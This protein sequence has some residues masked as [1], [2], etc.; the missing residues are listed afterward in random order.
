MATPHASA[1]AAVV[2]SLHTGCSAEQIR[3]S[4]SK[5]AMDLGTAGRDFEYGHGLVQARAAHDRI[6]ALG[7]GN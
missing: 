3:A 5:S 2:W 7:C 1:V 4:L 6:S